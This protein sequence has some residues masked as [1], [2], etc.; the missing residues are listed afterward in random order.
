MIHSNYS[1]LFC[2]VNRPLTSETLFRK[3]GDGK[4]II[5]NKNITKEEEESRIMKYYYS[6]YSAF[7]EI[8]LKINPKIIISIHSFNPVY[9]GVKREVEVGILSS[10]SN[11]FSEK[12]IE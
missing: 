9:E 5:L 6:Y 2:D 10:F 7:R 3:E 8:S 12:V 11:E 4:E 1:R